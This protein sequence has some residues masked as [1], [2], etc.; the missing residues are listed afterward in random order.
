MSLIHG[1][2]DFFALDIGTNSIRLI[3]L[4]GSANRGWA[5]D[6]F[7]YVPVDANLLMDDSESG[8]HRM[9]EVMLGAIEQA[10]IKTKNVAVGL[11]AGKTYTTVIELPNAS[12]KDLKRVAK[13]EADQYVPMASEEAKIDYAV[14]GVSPNDAGRAEVLVSSVN[15]SYAEEKLRLLEAIGLNVVAQEPE[16]LAMARALAPL[17]VNDGRLLIDLGE[18]SI[19]IVMIYGG[20]PRLVRSVPGGFSIF[21]KTLANALSVDEN[22]AKQ[23]ILKFGLAQDQMDGAI[24]KNLSGA[25]D[26]FASELT[27]SIGFFK[28]K[29]NNAEVGGIVLSGF[30]GMIP[31]IAE[32]IEA[33]TGIATVQGNP[34]QYVKVTSKQQDVLLP[35][36]SE[37]AVAIGLAERSN[38]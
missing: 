13:Y 25:L 16:P 33:K 4:K 11:P 1:V 36:A 28:N 21:T 30:A 26:S 18:K 8:K 35:M 31:F 2:G 19:D 20:V 6:K 17:E 3:Q 27:K 5:L 10:G 38:D 23:M 7:A 12:E 29:Y 34:W 32:Y 37:F 15:K 14:L 24:F 9:G 22:Q